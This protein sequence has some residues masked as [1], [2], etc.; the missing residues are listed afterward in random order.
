[1]WDK[2]IKPLYVDWTPKCKSYTEL[3]IHGFCIG[4]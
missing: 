2:I 3:E 4:K 1:M